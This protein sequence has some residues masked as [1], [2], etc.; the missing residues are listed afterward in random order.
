MKA[1][2]LLDSHFFKQFKGNEKFM[3]FMENP[4]SEVSKKLRVN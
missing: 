3:A 4:T 2:D 1:E